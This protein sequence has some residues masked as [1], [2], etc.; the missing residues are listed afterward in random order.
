MSAPYEAIAVERLRAAAEDA[1]W[2]VAREYRPDRVAAFVAEERGLGALEREL[3]AAS[4]AAGAH[5]RHHIARE[6]DADD[7]RKRPLRVE[8]ESLVGT[9]AAALREAPILES[10]AGVCLDPCRVA[11][12]LPEPLAPSCEA[13][14]KALASLAPARIELY[15]AASTHRAL[16]AAAGAALDK[17]AGKIARTHKDVADLAEA[18]RG[19]TYVVSSEPRVLDACGTWLNVAK[20]VVDELGVETLT[21]AT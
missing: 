21:L 17:C 11:G 5:H 18:L 20:R 6:L 1:A 14:A 12:A 13:L 10:V 2:L 16:V 19:A 9:I 7:A 8:V 3:L 4:A 15:W